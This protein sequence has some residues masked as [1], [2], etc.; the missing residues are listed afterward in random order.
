[1]AAWDHRIG[2]GADLPNVIDVVCA[3]S[4]D[5]G[6]TWGAPAVLARH[7]GGDTPATAWGCGDVC[8]LTDP[9][10]GR[11]FA[12][13]LYAPP[14]VGYANSD[15]STSPSTTTSVR[16]CCRYSDDDGVTWSAQQELI[17]QVK[18]S[19]MWGLFAS[20]G[21][22][23]VGADGTLYVPYSYQV[24]AGS[25]TSGVFAAFS[26]DHGQTWQRSALITANNPGENHGV[27]LSDGSFLISA[28]PGTPGAR[29]FF[30]APSMAGPWTASVRPDLPDPSC[31]GDLVRVDPDDTS[32]RRDWLLV[33]GCAS[34]ASRTNLT[35]WLSTDRGATW[36]AAWRVFDG[37]A[38]YSSM[39]RLG[40][41]TFGIFWEDTVDGVMQFTPFGLGVFGA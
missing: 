31:N 25:S 29:R 22:G 16:P 38:A 24:A 33:S 18:T 8:L 36:P 12:H 3:R 32:A 5:G 6:A 34:T 35:V 4:T 11:I 13:Y 2:S 21:H 40:D 15:N 20:S 37:G 30:T 7:T 23:W 19:A 26:A 14:G 28:R 39:V 9:A 10:T 1:M 41:G 27:Q 17:G